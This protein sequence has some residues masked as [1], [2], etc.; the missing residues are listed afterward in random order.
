MS[1]SKVWGRFRLN[2]R[3]FEIPAY[4]DMTFE[5]IELVEDTLDLPFPEALGQFARSRHKALRAFA[6]IAIRRVREDVTMDELAAFRIGQLDL[7][8]TDSDEESTDPPTVAA[9]EG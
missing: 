1:E 7:D 8:L 5:E 6:F 4:E 3:E 2:G 9:S